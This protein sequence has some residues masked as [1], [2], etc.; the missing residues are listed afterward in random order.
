[1][2]HSNHFIEIGSSNRSL[3]SDRTLSFKEY[4]FKSNSVNQPSEPDLK[5]TSSNST[6]RS[7]YFSKQNDHDH[8]TLLL[9]EKKIKNEGFKSMIS[10]SK[11]F[12]LD[13]SFNRKE[14]LN[15]QL[16]CQ[17]P[18]SSR[19]FRG[20][21][22]IPRLPGDPRRGSG[23]GAVLGVQLENLAGFSGLGVR[24]DAGEKLYLAGTPKTPHS[25]VGAQP[26]F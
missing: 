19:D 14:N 16:E 17:S 7:S 10:D 15:D 13:L 2:N 26:D 8:D 1:M 23:P 4:S 6:E 21:P 9:K 11:R 24:S 25:G 12:K 3:E 22:E 5:Q 18:K 20:L